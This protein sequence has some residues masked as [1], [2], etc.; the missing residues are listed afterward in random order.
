M[1]RALES[2]DLPLISTSFVGGKNLKLYA[3]CRL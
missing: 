1:E 3:K 2:S